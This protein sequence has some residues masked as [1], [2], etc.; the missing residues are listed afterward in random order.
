MVFKKKFIG[1]VLDAADIVVNKTSQN[2]F[3]ATVVLGVSVKT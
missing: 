2:F 3:P 1:T